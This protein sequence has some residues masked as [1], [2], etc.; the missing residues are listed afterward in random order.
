MRVPSTDGVDLE[1]HDFG[2]DGPPLLIAHATGMCAGAYL[3]MVP[4]LARV[5]HVWAIDFRAHGD[6]TVPDTGDLAWTG[7]AADV[8]AAVDAIGGGP[9]AGFGHS[10]GGASLIAAELQRPGLLTGA[11][12]FEP[13]IVPGAFAFGAGE[14]PMAAA[15]R[16]RRAGFASRDHALGRYARRPPLGGWRA[17]ALAAYVD[18][19]FADAPDGS[20]V[21]K[22]TPEHEAQTFEGSGKITVDQVTVVA[23]PTVIARGGREG[24]F[25]PAGFAGLIADALPHGELRRYPELSHF[26][27]FEDPVLMA[28]EAVAFLSN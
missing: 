18:H 3:P 17:D 7:M 27:P 21:L 19:G 15:A 16:R 20:V 4:I 10:M 9:V 1:L 22:C 23:T 6:S 13:I 24:E 25:G 26:G 12:L 28:R 11:Y 2:G 14:N 5:F 8:L